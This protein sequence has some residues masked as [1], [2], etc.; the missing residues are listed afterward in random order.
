LALVLQSG[1]RAV[2]DPAAAAAALLPL[3]AAAARRRLVPLLLMMMLLIMPRFRGEDDRQASS[4]LLG[5][6]ET[7]ML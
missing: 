6:V 4:G 5:G 1:S 7:S 2:V 3:A